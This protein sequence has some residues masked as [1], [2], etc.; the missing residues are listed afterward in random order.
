MNRTISHCLL[1]CALVTSVGASSA[2]ADID[3]LLDY[4]NFESGLDAITL[5]LGVASFNSDEISQIQSGI[6][7]RLENVY[8]GYNI[9]FSTTTPGG[10]H[11]TI[12][13]GETDGSNGI[14][15]G[16]ADRIDYRNV[17]KDD[18]A[19]V[20]TQSFAD[21][22]FFFG[23]LSSRSRLM[24]DVSTV[25]AGTAAHELGHNLGLQHHDPYG[26]VEFTGGEVNG[27]IGVGSTGGL[28][29]QH[30]MATGST[31]L[32]EAGRLQSRTLS[33]LSHAKLEFADGIVDNVLASTLEVTTDHDT[34]AT[35]QQLSFQA[36]EN[37][38][39]RYNDGANVIGNIGASGEEDLYSFV[40]NAGDRIA[41]NI[42]SEVIFAND[43]DSVLSLYDANGN[44]IG[45][46]DDIQYDS[47][48]IINGFVNSQGQ[49]VYQTLDAMI[50]NYELSAAGTYFIGVRAF[51]TDDLGD[52]EMF[53]ARSG[54]AVPEPT[55]FSAVCIICTV[56][57]LIRRRRQRNAHDR[58]DVL[59][60]V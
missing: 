1:I 50:L 6:Q 33:D 51:S 29:N 23:S 19:R 24:D 35:A 38:L 40:A 18:V 10:V 56:G 15:F 42:L 9:G 37:G 54:A 5:N 12:T 44:L 22:D 41:V 21:A 53:I 55:T 20:Y 7:S 43:L 26:S 47:D 28:Q 34:I 16:E 31:G 11:E 8:A 48:E 39:T 45:I 17:F 52:Y 14:I 58:Q 30:I 2:K 4:T 60:T 59:P 32:N 13:F 46:H 27:F 3:V 57:W 49:Y 36:F 25:I